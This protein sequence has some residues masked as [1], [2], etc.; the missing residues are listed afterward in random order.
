MTF[1]LSLIRYFLNSNTLVPIPL[2]L[3]RTSFALP[4]AD[5]QEHIL[6]KKSHIQF[7]NI[8]EII[9]TCTLIPLF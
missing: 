9:L 7:E 8:I 3:R 4:R 2:Q 6:Q 1:T 5:N